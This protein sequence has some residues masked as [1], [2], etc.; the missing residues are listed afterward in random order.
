MNEAQ[1]RL[2]K[3]IGAEFELGESTPDLLDWLY[4][5]SKGLMKVLDSY[6]TSELGVLKEIYYT[7]PPPFSRNICRKFA[8]VGKPILSLIT[9]VFKGDK[10]IE[11][12]L[13]NTVSQVGFENFELILVDCASPG[14]EKRIIDRYLDKHKN[15]RYIRLENDPGLYEAWNIGA[16]E[17]QGEFLS[18]A[19]LDDRKS[20]A[21]YSILLDRIISSGCDMIS[22]LFWTCRTLPEEDL[23]DW[24]VIWYKNASNRISY[25]DFLKLEN[26]GIHDQCLVGPFPI[27]RKRLHAEHG[28]FDESN[29]G[30]SSDY[31]FWMR[32][33]SQGATGEFYKVPIGYYL[34]CPNSYARRENNAAQF[35]KQI[36]SKYF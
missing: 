24:P 13:S 33:V 29:F 15:I 31:E 32:C 10:Y 30:P 6:Y 19:N 21:Y 35:N 23:K 11:E 28:F 17:A 3:K 18:N 16:R 34:R 36:L 9:S 25:F 4:V 2:I 1:T 27:W 8:Q 12:F 14:S 5:P 7:V 20:I 22:S 26:G